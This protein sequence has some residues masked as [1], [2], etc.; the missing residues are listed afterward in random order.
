MSP[1]IIFNGKEYNHP[2]EMPAEA[3][4][5]YDQAMQI[6][7][8]KNRDGVPDFLEHGMDILQGES[9]ASPPAEGDVSKSFQVGMQIFSL[10]GKNYTSLEEMPPEV[11]RAYEQSIR[12]L[13]D[14]NQDGVP[15]IL[16][17]VLGASPSV[18]VAQPG[19]PVRQPLVSPPSGVVEPSRADKRLVLLF[20]ALGLGL[21]ACLVVTLVA[22]GVIRLPF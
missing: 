9:S 12:V 16:E 4:R 3:R 6:F 1:K 11:R 22:L 14:A 8:D 17:G 18:P 2:D 20:V 13:A 15:D 5:A 10:D 19:P 7:S 21:V